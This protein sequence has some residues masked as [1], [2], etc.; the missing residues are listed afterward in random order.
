ML[1]EYLR[2]QGII[3]NPRSN[4]PYRGDT[5]RVLSLL[6]SKIGELGQKGAKLRS[7]LR[8]SQSS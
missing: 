4:T 8:E 5:E 1:K 6:E 7:E 2:R 3:A